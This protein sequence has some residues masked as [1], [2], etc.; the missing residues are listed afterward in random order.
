MSE[1]RHQVLA[2]WPSFARKPVFHSALARPGPAHRRLDRPM[3]SAKF[4]PQCH[5]KC[6]FVVGLPLQGARLCPFSFTSL[7]PP[8]INLWGRHER[9]RFIFCA[10]VHPIADASMIKSEAAMA[11]SKPPLSSAP[12]SLSPTLR[13]AEYVRMSTEHQQYSAQNQA[14]TICEFAEHRGIEIIMTYS[15]DAKSRL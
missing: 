3:R 5:G 15:D 2:A 13:A 6:A 12:G 8:S 4:G 7:R 9:G 11:G 10:R 1:W 14:K